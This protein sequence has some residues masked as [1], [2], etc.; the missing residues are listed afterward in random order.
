LEVIVTIKNFVDCPHTFPTVARWLIEEFFMDKPEHT[1]ENM[2]TRMQGAKRDKIPL[3]LISFEEE[4][5]SGV[6]SLLENDLGQPSPLTPWLAGLYVAPEFRGKGIGK[7]LVSA[8]VAE[9]K[10]LGFDNL[11]LYTSTPSFYEK[12]G[13]KIDSRIEDSN[14]FALSYQ[15]ATEN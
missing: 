12:I 10:R 6:V 15:L 5:P 11:Y 7:L 14:T 4:V 9:A 13:W 8:C 1:V 3:G 2:V